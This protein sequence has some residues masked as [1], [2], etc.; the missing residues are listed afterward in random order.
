MFLSQV[1]GALC[2]DFRNDWSLLLCK[3]SS[4][5]AFEI[6]KVCLASI[7]SFMSSYAAVSY[8]EIANSTPKQHTFGSMNRRVM[9]QFAE[10]VFTLL[11]GD[12]NHWNSLAWNSSWISH[13]TAPCSVAKELVATAKPKN[14]LMYDLNS[15]TI[16]TCYHN[17]FYPLGTRNRCGHCQQRLEKIQLQFSE[18]AA[19]CAHSSLVCYN[20]RT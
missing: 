4:T 12:G 19:T 5:S 3:W 9:L 20:F 7:E 11:I 1:K 6:E 14:D 13:W 8:Q 16:V 10:G 18:N 17:G 2:N 15:A